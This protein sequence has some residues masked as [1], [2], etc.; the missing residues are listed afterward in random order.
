MFV[1]EYNVTLHLTNNIMERLPNIPASL[2]HILTLNLTIKVALTLN[3][4]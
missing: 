4:T 1:F 2:I 3:L